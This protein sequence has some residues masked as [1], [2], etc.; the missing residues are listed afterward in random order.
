MHAHAHIHTRTH[1]HTQHTHDSK[2]LHVSRSFHLLDKLAV[3]ELAVEHLLVQG[4][5]ISTLLVQKH[6]TRTVESQK[7][8]NLNVRYGGYSSTLCSANHCQDG[9][10]H[11]CMQA[12]THWL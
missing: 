3:G 6:S 5:D 1:T 10:D 11:M 12:L 7:N 2:V 4:A 8:E 9:S